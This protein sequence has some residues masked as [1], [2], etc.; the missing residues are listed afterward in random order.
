MMN[1]LRLTASDCLPVALCR[2][3]A[4]RS[5]LR[6]DAGVQNYFG[7]R[8]NEIKIDNCAFGPRGPTVAVGTTVTWA[9]HDDVPY[10][11]VDKNRAFRSKTLDTSNSFSFRPSMLVGAT[12]SAAFIRI[13]GKLIVK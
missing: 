10:T 1:H 13:C 12:I 8:G 9:N 2:C 3:D 6:R 7:G 4:L 11:V 5:R